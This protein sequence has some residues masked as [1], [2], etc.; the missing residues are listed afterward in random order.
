M[1]GIEVKYKREHVIQTPTEI[2]IA[3]PAFYDINNFFQNKSYSFRMKNKKNFLISRLIITQYVFNRNKSKLSSNQML[4]FN[5]AK[6]LLLN[7]P[8]EYEAAMSKY[9]GVKN[10]NTFVP[11]ISKNNE[12]EVIVNDKGQLFQSSVNNIYGFH[13]CPHVSKATV[14]ILNDRPLAIDNSNEKRT[15]I[16]LNNAEQF[17]QNMLYLFKPAKD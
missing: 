8:K 2:L 9:E 1:P 14:L 6:I 13:Y 5:E 10:K 16:A 4:V 15:E 17:A 7:T 11:L 3:D 12:Y